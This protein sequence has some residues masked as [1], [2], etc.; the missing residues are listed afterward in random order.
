MDFYS[1]VE[2]PISHMFAYEALV[3]FMLYK[4]AGLNTVIANSLSRCS[5]RVQNKQSFPVSNQIC[6]ANTNIL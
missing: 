3:W 6:T 2:L 4:F 5:G 1:L